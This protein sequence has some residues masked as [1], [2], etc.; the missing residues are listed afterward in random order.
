MFTT[1][2][3]TVIIQWTK[4]LMPDGMHNSNNNTTLNIKN[5]RI[6]MTKVLKM[7]AKS[8]DS[9]MDHTQATIIIQASTHT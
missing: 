4:V 5:N 2:I 9:K 6:N 1:S 7:Q 8:T 3:N